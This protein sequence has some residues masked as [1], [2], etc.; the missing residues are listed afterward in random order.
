VLNTNVVI[1]VLNDRPAPV[2]EIF[3]RHVAAR[4]AMFVPTIVLF[5]LR[6]GIAK[7]ARKAANE[8]KLGILL[9]R[10]IAV[11]PFD[12][13]D[14]QAAGDLR[15]LLEARGTLVGPYDLLIA[16]QALRRSA[17]LVTSNTKEFQRVEGLSLE[18]WTVT[19]DR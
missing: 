16:A 15:A 6:F 12:E 13:D 5:E 9:R 3:E 11:L 14:A 2:R 4:D 18:D 10:A 8:Q 7:S 1:A 17:T 19:D